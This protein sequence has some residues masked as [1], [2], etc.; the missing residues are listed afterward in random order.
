MN[1]VARSRAQG[2]GRK[3]PS[4][5]AIELNRI[6]YARATGQLDLF[7]E[8]LEEEVLK[9]DHPQRHRKPR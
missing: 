1:K 4:A 3:R 5:R 2:R 8:E 9:R 6:F 7:P